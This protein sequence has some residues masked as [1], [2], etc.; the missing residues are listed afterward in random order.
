MKSQKGTSL[1]EIIV[2]IA[3]VGFLVILVSSLPNSINLITKAKHLSIAREVIAK[4]IENQRSIQ[5]INLVNGEVS[6]PRLKLLPSSSG[7]VLIEDCNP[8]ICTN[9][10]ITKVVTITV[11]WKESGK[12]TS[13]KVK[14]F[15]SE[16]GLNK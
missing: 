10:E 9:G 7:N 11:S 14:T 8:S 5:Y 16:G 1:V 13:T 3:V 4:E 15:I 12:D 6:D 2:V